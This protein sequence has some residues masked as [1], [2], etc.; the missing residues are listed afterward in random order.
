V[1]AFQLLPK[2][3]GGELN[4]ALTIVAGHFQVLL[5]SQKGKGVGQW[6]WHIS[7]PL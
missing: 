7:I 4:V 2:G 5:L 6:Y 1:R 3:V